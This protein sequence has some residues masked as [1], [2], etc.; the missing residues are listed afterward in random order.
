MFLNVYSFNLDEYLKLCND[1]TN[2]KYK[3]KFP[4]N[5]YISEYGINNIYKLERH[6]K[7][8]KQYGINADSIIFY[9]YKTYLNNRIDTACLAHL[10]STIELG[11]VFMKSN[12]IITDST[13]IYENIG[14]YIISKCV[15]SLEKKLKN[16][17]YYITDE[18]IKYLIVKLEKNGFLIKYD[19]PDSEKFWMHVK[20]GNWKYLCSKIQSR[21]Y[22]YRYICVTIIISFIILILIAI[23]FIRKKNKN[24]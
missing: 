15:Y 11:I 24:K 21:C 4:Y 13:Y 3:I 23:K 5:K 17:E 8:L 9:I 16:K 12:G 2:K 10:S 6:R 18:N 14:D 7:I 19:K 22:D 20:N 1:S